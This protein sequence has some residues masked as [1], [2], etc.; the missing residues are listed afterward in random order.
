MSEKAVFQYKCDEY[1]A[2]Q[3][4]AA[5]L[6]SDPDLGID[7]GLPASDVIVSEKDGRNQTFKEY[8]ERK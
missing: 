7:W 3:S 6:W 5:L 4:E 1:Y 2:P 8:L